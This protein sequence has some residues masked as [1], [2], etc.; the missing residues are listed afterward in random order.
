MFLSCYVLTPSPPP[1]ST[2]NN[3]LKVYFYDL[4]LARSIIFFQ[5]FLWRAVLA[6]FVNMLYIYTEF[7]TDIYTM[8]INPVQ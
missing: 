1:R 2:V 7:L 5:R 4:I 6:H 3:K 8:R